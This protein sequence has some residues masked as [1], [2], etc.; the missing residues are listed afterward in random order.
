MHDVNHQGRVIELFIMFADEIFDLSQENEN[1]ITRT[2][3]FGS[4]DKL[5]NQSEDIQ[6]S[7]TANNENHT[8]HQRILYKSA[9]C[10][11]LQPDVSQIRHDISQARLNFFAP[12]VNT[13]TNRYYSSYSQPNDVM[14]PFSQITAASSPAN[15][16]HNNRMKRTPS[17]GHNL[18]SSSEKPSTS[19]IYN[20]HNELSR[21]SSDIYS[22]KNMNISITPNSE[23]HV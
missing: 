5:K 17:V 23:E 12:N 20:K 22:H 19:R 13:S 10:S 18:M 16:I 14:S 21:S 7:A 4:M 1:Y 8:N 6:M 2:N 15:F 9:T 3:S 11:S